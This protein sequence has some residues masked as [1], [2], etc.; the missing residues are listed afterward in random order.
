[1]ADTF[2]NIEKAV[3]GRLATLSNL[4][5]VQWPNIDNDDDLPKHTESFFRLTHIPSASDLS[6]LNNEHKFQGFYQIDIFVPTEIGTK[7]L[8]EYADDIKDHFD[9][10]TLTSGSDRV[11]IQEVFPL[12]IEKQ[13]AWFV[14]SMQINYICYS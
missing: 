9:R 6:T 2:T 11:F 14:C 12:V 7:T 10:Q 8:Y 1:M 4:P 3:Q 5:S 13:E